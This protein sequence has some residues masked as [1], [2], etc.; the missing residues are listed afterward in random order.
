MAMQIARD[1]RVHVSTVGDNGVIV[2]AQET[3]V[4]LGT[5]VNTTRLAFVRRTYP[6]MYNHAVRNMNSLIKQTKEKEKRSMRGGHFFL[7]RY[8]VLLAFLLCFSFGIASIYVKACAAV[9]FTLS[10]LHIFLSIYNIVI[11]LLNHPLIHP[12]LAIYLSPGQM[13][14]SKMQNMF[15]TVPIQTS[16]RTSGLGALVDPA[17]IVAAVQLENTHVNEIQVMFYTDSYIRDARFPRECDFY[18]ILF[19]IMF[20]LAIIFVSISISH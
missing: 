9:S 6:A 2:V 16:V 11:Y 7:Y 18:L 3:N 15:Y 12:D 17:R 1:N 5:P 13:P 10:I 14:D 20:I 19:I 8:M 4:R